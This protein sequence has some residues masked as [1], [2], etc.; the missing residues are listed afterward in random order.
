MFFRLSATI[1]RSWDYRP[2]GLNQGLERCPVLTASP[3]RMVATYLHGCVQRLT[4]N[5]CSEPI[6]GRGGELGQVGVSLGT[7][8]NRPSPSTPRGLALVW[9]SQILIVALQRAERIV[10]KLRFPENDVQTPRM[11]VT[12]RVSDVS[13]EERGHSHREGSTGMCVSLYY[14]TGCGTA[15]PD[16]DRQNI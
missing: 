3:R 5:P 11:Q 16:M 13:L 7:D 2:R 8:S 9:I 10:L 14:G 1:C 6:D 12:N 4:R 15:A